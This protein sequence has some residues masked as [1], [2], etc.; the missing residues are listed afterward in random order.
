M[1]A[2]LR[3]LP[4]VIA[5]LL[6][7]ATVMTSGQEAAV[8]LTLEEAVERGLRHSMRLAEAQARVDAAS[9]VEAGR[10]AAERPLISLQS[11][12]TR[13]N[14]VEAFFITTPGKLPSVLYPDVPD[15][16]RARLDLQW[17]I[18]TAGRADALERA[19]RAER[20]AAGADL[21]AAR[22]DLRLE[23][24][25]AFW[26]LVT[27]GEAEQVLARAVDSMDAHLRDLRVR[28]DQGLIPPNEVLSAEAQRSRE[29]LLAIEARNARAIAEAELRRLIGD[30]GLAGPSTGLAQG[31]AP[32]VDSFER[33]APPAVDAS[34]LLGQAQALR[35][36]RRALADRAAAAH[37]RA[38]AIEAGGRP[39]IAVNGGYDYARPNP[40]IFPRIDEWH[41]SWDVS[42][43]VSWSLW[44]GGRRR[45]EQVEAAAG[46]RALDARATDFDR[47]LAFEIRQR[48]LEAQSAQAAIDAAGDGVRAA[49][50]AR[51]VVAERFAAGVATSTDVLDAETAVLQAELDRTRAVAN[52]RLTVARLDRAIGR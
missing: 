28:L 5:G 35:P 13:T 33:M 46:A 11:G 18:F 40:R 26:A 41:D 7:G 48:W 25:R 12:Y 16:Y 19:A 44:D 4:A 47:H 6:A 27:A 21:E 23:I 49:V 52:A 39:Q 2:A 32:A 9:A 8:R 24:T 1:K 17:P 36:E 51:R 43:N 10:M 37:A 42:V 29:R 38:A 30:D 22:A 20:S 45:A 3:V 14:H 50:E 15:N 34:A 31:I